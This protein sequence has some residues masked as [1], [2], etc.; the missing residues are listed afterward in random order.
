MIFGVGVYDAE[1]GC[2][3]PL[4]IHWKNMLRRCY[5]PKFKEKQPT[6]AGCTVDH[7]WLHLSN[8]LSWAE[9]NEHRGM[10]LDKDIFGPKLKHYSPGTCCFITRRMNNCIRSNSSI[11]P[12]VIKIGEKFKARLNR[13][14]LG[15]F[16]TESEALSVYRLNK[17]N[18]IK[19]ICKS[20]CERVR[21]E[22]LSWE[23]LPI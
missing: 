15:V 8:F 19:S 5:C 1:I 3:D 21:K 4:Y 2:K 12:G 23:F 20:E 6:Y 11:S 9:L 18:Y 22:I 16:E 7:N 13:L 17:L 14:S 10:F